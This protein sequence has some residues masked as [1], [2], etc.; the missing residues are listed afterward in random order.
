MLVLAVDVPVSE[1]VVLGRIGLTSELM[2]EVVLL[3]S[4]M[5]EL[6]VTVEFI[7]DADDV[8]LDVMVGDTVGGPDHSVQDPFHVPVQEPVHAGVDVAIAE[9]TLRR[10]DV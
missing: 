8:V 1:L 9:T 7:V 10:L 3:N 5:V 2:L 6:P 4:D